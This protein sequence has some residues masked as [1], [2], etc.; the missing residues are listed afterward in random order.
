MGLLVALAATECLIVTATVALLLGWPP[1]AA[2]VGAI[3]VT[4]LAAWV[5]LANAQ[6]SRDQIANALRLLIRTVAGT[7]IASILYITVILLQ[8]RLPTGDERTQL[9]LSLAGSVIAA[10]GVLATR[11]QVGAYADRATGVIDDEAFSHLDV[12]GARITEPLPLEEVLLQIVETLRTALR[13]A[14]AEIWLV[15][16]TV[17]L[18]RVAA[19]PHRGLS[20]LEL[21]QPTAAALA[22]LRIGGDA[23][24]RVW[25]PALVA[26]Q[27]E[28]GRVVTPIVQ[29]GEVLGAVILEQAFGAAPLT[30]DGERLLVEVARRVGLAVRN[31]R[32]DSALRATLADV[33]AQAE[34]LRLSRARVV[35]AADAERRRIERNLHDGAQQHLVA[36]AGDLHRARRLAVSDPRAASLVLDQVAADVDETLAALRELAQGIYPSLLADQGLV[37]ALRSAARRAVPSAEIRVG[38]TLPRLPPEVESAIYFCCLEALQNV[39]K[40]AG[41]PGCATID[42]EVDNGALCFRIN[43]DGVGFDPQ[44]VEGGT[45]L[46]GMADRLGAVGGRVVV[47]SAVG[48]GTTVVGTVP[49]A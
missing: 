21:N 39:A 48:S 6:L 47:E 40:H 36:L 9:A 10:A 45:G 19:D 22:G 25:L 46:N 28:R 44:L 18:E 11:S 27:P 3:A 41:G 2:A 1:P 15:S 7:A 29:S 13:L 20:T 16:E 35:A 23:W 26:E 33:Q 5:V 14:A 17:V 12:L 42:F 31:A 4:A 8:G 37:Q 43:D 38:T 32:L 24:L 49:M 34:Q 30:P